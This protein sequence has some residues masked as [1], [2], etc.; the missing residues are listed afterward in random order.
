MI[1]LK[2]FDLCLL[3]F[4]FIFVTILYFNLNYNDVFNINKK[5]LKSHLPRIVIVIGTRPEAIKCAPLISVLKNEN[6]KHKFEVLVLSTGQHREIPRK[7]LGSFSQSV[8]IDLDLMTKNQD[9]SLFFNS[10]FLK[11]TNEFKR[12][13]DVALVVVQGDTTTALA[14]ALAAS[15]LHIPVAHVEAGLRSYDMENPYPEEMN[16]KIIDAVSHLMMAPTEYSKQALI[17]EGVCPSDIFVTGNTGIDAF[18][19]LQKMV[20]NTM[21]KLLTDIKQFKSQSQ[22][23]S[24]ILVTMHDACMICMICMMK[25]FSSM[26]NASKRK[27]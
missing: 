13:N 25:I 6:Y 5:R 14:A 24:V 17:N 19:S 12:L 4:F 21:P 26:H 10:A 2:N 15:Y 9:I 22:E 7:T 11:I 3:I 20:P 23:K 16:R 1:K 18:Y 27:F 8:D